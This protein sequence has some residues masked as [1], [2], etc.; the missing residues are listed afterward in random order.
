MGEA[1]TW[2]HGHFYWNELMTRDVEGAK[3]FYRKIAGWQFEGMAM[4]DGT[5]WLCKDGET[6]VGGIF[7]H[8]R[9]AFRGRA[10]AVVRLSGG[11]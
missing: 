11:G 8:Q 4:E 6:P 9:G 7:G 2:Q 5:Y 10:G 3:V 1:T